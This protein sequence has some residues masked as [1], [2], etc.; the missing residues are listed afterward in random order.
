MVIVL[1]LELLSRID[2]GCVP[3]SAASRLAANANSGVILGNDHVSLVTSYLL[4]VLATAKV[5]TK[6]NAGRHAC[7]NTTSDDGGCV[8]LVIDCAPSAGGCCYM[9]KAANS[10]AICQFVPGLR[11]CGDSAPAQHALARN[12]HRRAGVRG[13][14]RRMASVEPLLGRCFGASGTPMRWQRAS[15]AALP[16]GHRAGRLDRLCARLGRGARTRA[17][18]PLHERNEAVIPACP[19]RLHAFDDARPTM[20]GQ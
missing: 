13:E 2:G 3:T 11:A 8:A 10:Q 18:A 17:S 1:T 7:R 5:G 4:A 9:T 19:C 12:A 15:P 16:A 6:T 20:A 14:S